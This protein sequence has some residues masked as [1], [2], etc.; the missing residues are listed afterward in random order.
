MTDPVDEREMNMDL[1]FLTDSREVPEGML[2]T[3]HDRILKDDGYGRLVQL[4]DE[5]YEL[6]N[7][8]VTVS[9]VGRD[10]FELPIRDHDYVAADGSVR[11]ASDIVVMPDASIRDPRD[12][13][14]GVIDWR[15]G[16]TIGD[17]RTTRFRIDGRAATIVIEDPLALATDA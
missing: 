7:H 10:P 3:P 16:H 5:A 15:G 14:D 2:S 12:D 1:P 4:L 6:H 17:Q 9:I 8:S 13:G 11:L